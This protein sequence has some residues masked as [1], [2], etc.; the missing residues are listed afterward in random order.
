MGWVW[1][2]DTERMGNLFFFLKICLFLREQVGVEG[3]KERVSTHTEGEGK[4]DFPLSRE[5]DL[6][7]HPKTLGSEP[8]PKADV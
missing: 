7:L 5:P 2:E 6:G 4:A 3:E 1:R 8:E